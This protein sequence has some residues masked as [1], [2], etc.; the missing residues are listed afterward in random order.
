MDKRYAAWGARWRVPLGFALGIGYLIFCQPTPDLTLGGG[1][2]ALGGVGLRAFAAG[3]LE[4][5]VSLARGGPYRVTRNP[6]YLGSLLMG[7]GFAVA[8]GS[9]WLGLALLILF[10]LVYWPVM[11]REEENLRERFGEIYARY[12]ERVPLFF[13][14]WPFRLS[15]HIAPRVPAKF[16]W[17]WYRKNREYRAALGYLAGMIFLNLKIRLR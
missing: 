2:I 13:P 12:A 9:V 5:N 15:E 1:V 3:Y 4:K 16:Q 17:E 14:S 8:G 6:L 10:V 11:L 7:L